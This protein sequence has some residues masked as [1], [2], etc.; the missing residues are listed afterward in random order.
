VTYTGSE[1]TATISLSGNGG[2]T[3]RTLTLSYGATTQTLS[4]RSVRANPM[5]AGQAYLM[6][7]VVDWI[8]TFTGWSATLIDNTYAATDLGVPFNH[9]QGKSAPS[10]AFSAVN[11]K[12]T[13]FNLITAVDVHADG[14][15]T[16]TGIHNENIVMFDT[17][18]H[19]A[20]KILYIAN[21]PTDD[22]IVANNQFIAM[23][24]TGNYYTTSSNSPIG[25]PATQHKHV[26][27]VH[28]SWVAQDVFVRMNDSEADA[29]CLFANNVFRR[30][31]GTSYPPRANVV[32]G[33]HIHGGYLSPHGVLNGVPNGTVNTTVGGDDASLFVDAAGLDLTPAGELLANLKTPVVKFGVNRVA[34]GAT[35]PAGAVA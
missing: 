31:L 18:F 14:Y 21:E 20:G 28:N 3:S 26:V 13:V 10:R 2:A 11:V 35:A 27:V 17:Y 15:Q 34:R 12:D 30:F 4:I 22:F 32:V 9:P 23:P 19:M 6:S 16:R 8:N 25:P 33:N 7:E 24:D 5:P 1:A 29:Y